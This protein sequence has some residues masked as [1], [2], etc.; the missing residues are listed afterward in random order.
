MRKNCFYLFL[1][2]HCIKS[3]ASFPTGSAIAIL[4]CNDNIEN[5][6]RIYSYDR[7]YK[8]SQTETNIRFVR[9]YLSLTY[10]YESKCQPFFSQINISL[11]PFPLSTSLP[12]NRMVSLE[13]MYRTMKC[14]TGRPEQFQDQI[15]SQW[16]TTCLDLTQINGTSNSPV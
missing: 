7:Y 16:K 15:C 8:K 5:E 12:F 4:S 11:I 6:R 9:T 2:K 1:S 10:W 3:T 13:M 14:G